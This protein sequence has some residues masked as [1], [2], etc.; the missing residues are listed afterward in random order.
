MK[1]L[2]LSL[3]MVLALTA[4]KDEKKEEVSALV[5]PVVKI[6]VS[7]P[8][9]GDM[10]N[11]GQVLKG[12]V[13]LAQQDIAKRDLKNEYQFVIEDN[14]FDLKRTALV[15]QK[16][17]SVDHVDAV[18]DFASKIGLVTSPVAEQ[19]KV[20]HISSCASDPKVAE[21]KY[22]FIHWTQTT[23]EVKKLVEKIIKE[24]LNNI[25]IFTAVDQATL[26]ISTNLQNLLQ[27]NGIDFKEIRTNPKEMDF[28]LILN[29]LSSDEPGLYVLLEYSP[30]LDIILKRLNESQN[31]VPV[32][33]IETF[34]FL[35]D[36]SVIEGFWFVDAAELNKD[37]YARFTSYN[38]SDNIFGVGNTYDALML[39]VNA[40]EKAQTKENAVEELSQIRAYNGVVGELNQDD[41]GIFNSKAILKKI[42]NGQP[43]EIEE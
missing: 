18:V 7:I 16:L 38:K 11:I 37:N 22:N 30:T 26:E 3:C 35:D 19:N 25:V 36:K 12:A 17:F 9:S 23:D 13:E 33:S 24:Q 20:I 29:K 21:G 2:L 34:S 42:V 41:N 31:T 4:C 39:L 1:K 28:N 6:G 32:T 5:K 14:A 15:N 27:E 8:L 43:V 10:A 40:F